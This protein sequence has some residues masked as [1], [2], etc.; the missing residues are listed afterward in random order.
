VFND[1]AYLYVEDEPLSREVMEIVMTQAMD[2]E[3]L[4][5]LHDSTDF[6][7]RVG[8]LSP[9]PDVFLLDIQVEPVDGYEMLKMLR[10][11]PDYRE[12][13]IV[14]V[15]ASVMTEQIRHLRKAGFD[16][17]IAK[18]VRVSSFPEVMERILRGDEV[19][20]TGN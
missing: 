16:A 17:A 12:A 18:P 8:A 20:F 9:P 7:A 4:T 14:A 13:C 1:H 6:M 19:W 11:R 3:H 15:T 2:V 10:A 5:I